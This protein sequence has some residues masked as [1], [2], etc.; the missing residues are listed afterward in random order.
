MAKELREK[1][2]AARGLSPDGPAVPLESVAAD[3]SAPVPPEV[4]DSA[5]PEIAVARSKD[6]EPVAA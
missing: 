4:A 3:G 5:A 2:F 1:I 6:R